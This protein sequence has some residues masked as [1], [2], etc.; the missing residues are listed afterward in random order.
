MHFSSL[1]L[2][3]LPAEHQCARR[4][5]ETR[6]PEPVDQNTAHGIE[7]VQH[8]H[9]IYEAQILVDWD[10]QIDGTHNHEWKPSDQRHYGD[11]KCR[12]GEAVVTMTFGFLLKISS[13]RFHSEQ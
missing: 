4:I 8:L 1:W 13:H 7:K 2:F 12:D 3:S 11:D 6:N 10:D 9:G 5:L